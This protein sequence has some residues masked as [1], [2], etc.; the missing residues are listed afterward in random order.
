M[1]PL[2]RDVLGVRH[3]DAEA[4]LR[5]HF[6]VE[7]QRE[8]AI[9]LRARRGLEITMRLV[10]LGERLDGTVTRH[11]HR[12]RGARQRHEA[13]AY[14]DDRGLSRGVVAN[15]LPLLGR[16]TEVDPKAKP[17]FARSQRPPR[18]QDL[19]RFGLAITPREPSARMR[20]VHFDEAP[21]QRMA[22]VE[23]A[24][25]GRKQRRGPRAVCVG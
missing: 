18:A 20:E 5:S 3:G 15:D 2:D 10:T 23:H 21:I 6:Q 16:Q 24:L 9:G 4:V 1:R 14:F 25:A 8:H 19:E 12:I 7:T 13:M 11:L 22:P 17:P